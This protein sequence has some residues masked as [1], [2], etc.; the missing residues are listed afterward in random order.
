MGKAPLPPDKPQNGPRRVLLGSL[1]AVSRYPRSALA[2]LA[3][4]PVALIAWACALP[5][6][7]ADLWLLMLPLVLA[8]SWI[9]GTRYATGLSVAAIVALWVMKGWTGTPMPTAA[10]TLLRFAALAVLAA[11]GGEMRRRLEESSR[12]DPLTGL[13]NERAFLD[14]LRLELLR[15]QRHGRPLGVIYTDLDDFGAFCRREGEYAGEQVLLHLARTSQKCLRRSDVIA[16]RRRRGDE[17]LV[18]LLETNTEGVGAA[19][20][21]LH[22]A[23]RATLQEAHVSLGVSMCS[24]AVTDSSEAPTDIIGDLEREMRRRKAAGRAG[25]EADPPQDERSTASS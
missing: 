21:R 19:R 7:N 14:S 2:T 16:L 8:V 5:G 20:K 25:G 15:Q 22:G 12:T 17:L 11:V 6:A 4:L 3:L 9:L 10:T 23:L 1:R 13:S 24:V 18:L